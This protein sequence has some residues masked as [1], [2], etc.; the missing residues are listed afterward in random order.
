MREVCARLKAP[1]KVTEETA[2][3]VLLH[4]Y[5]VDCR[6]RESKIRRMIVSNRDIFFKLVELK[7]ADFSACRDVLSEAPVITKW[8]EIYGEMM[9]EGV[10]FNLRELK[11]KGDEL[12][13][14][15]IPKEKCGKVLD[16]LLLECA[17]LPQLNEKNKLIITAKRILRDI[18]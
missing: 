15:G 17:V 7:Q 16:R 9:K 5:D 8:R 2:R 14:A 10:P 6:A 11:V 3:L 1:K 12:I 4:M 18:N 13:A